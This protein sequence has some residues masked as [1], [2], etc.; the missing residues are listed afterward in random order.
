MASA[1][2]SK[3]VHVWGG[4]NTYRRSERKEGVG[5]G[6]R[7]P[8]RVFNSLASARYFP[9]WRAAFSRLD[10]TQGL[11]MVWVG[12]AHNHAIQPI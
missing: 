3:G 1:L 7:A 4:L 11:P 12:L 5:S 8:I 2:I 6:E 9:V 10:L